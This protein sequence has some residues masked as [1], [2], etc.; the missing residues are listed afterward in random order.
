MGAR[1]MLVK[2]RVQRQDDIIHVIAHRIEDLTHWL[3][4]LAPDDLLVNPLARADEVTR[5]PPR[6][7]APAPDPPPAAEPHHPEITRFPVGCL[8]NSALAVVG[9]HHDGSWKNQ[10]ASNTT[11]RP[12]T[13]VR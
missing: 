11:T 10:L 9:S 2:G 7:L 8:G 5:S 4:R 13:S 3:A 12:A 1:L 6:R